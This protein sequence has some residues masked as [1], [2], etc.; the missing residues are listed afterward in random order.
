M[1]NVFLNRLTGHDRL[2]RVKYRL[3]LGNSIASNACLLRLVCLAFIRLLL[4]FLAIRRDVF[5]TTKL[6]GFIEMH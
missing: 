5:M 1:V 4:R 3:F 6:A 2:V